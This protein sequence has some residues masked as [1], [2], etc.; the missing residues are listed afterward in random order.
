MFVENPI[1]RFQVG[2]DTLG[3]HERRPGVRFPEL[4]DP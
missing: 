4:A 2:L 1:S 3:L